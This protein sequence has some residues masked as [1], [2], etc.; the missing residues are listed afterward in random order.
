MEGNEMKRAWSA[1]LAVLLMLPSSAFAWSPRRPGTVVVKRTV[2]VRRGVDGGAIAAGVLGGLV[3]GI[4][5]DRVLTPPPPRVVYYPQPAHHPPP[6]PPAAPRD[7]Y[8]EGYWDGYNEGVERGRRD[9]YEQ[10]K[11]RGYQDGYED[12]KSGRTL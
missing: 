10:G 5:L 8:E 1:V 9:R 4:I 6:P 3:T 11:R 2:V 12:A 7:S